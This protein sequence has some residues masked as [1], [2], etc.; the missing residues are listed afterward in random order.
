[1]EQTLF[2]EICG[3]VGS[4]GL[5]LGFLPQTIRTIRTRKTDDIALPTF[6]MMAVGAFF[7]MLQGL[8][9]RPDIIWSL[10][11]TNLVTCLCS[12]V[13]FGIKIYNYFVEK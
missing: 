6:L 9:H 13:V 3:Y 11:I 2:Y 4:V 7:F 8:L 10:F 1:M 5:I 12:C